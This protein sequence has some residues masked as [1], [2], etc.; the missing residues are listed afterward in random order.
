MTSCSF[1][2]DKYILSEHSKDFFFLKIS[3]K[4]SISSMFPFLQWE[5]V[6]IGFCLS[7]QKL[8]SAACS[9]LRL[10]TK[11]LLRNSVHVGRLVNFEFHG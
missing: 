6:H 11:T 7:C 10:G 9:C 1:L 3:Y 5:G 2:M 4:V 8:S